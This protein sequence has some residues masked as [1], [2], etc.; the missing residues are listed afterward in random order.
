MIVVVLKF[1]H[2]F[3][4][5]TACPPDI[6]TVDAANVRVTL[7]HTTLPSVQ[8]LM[9]SFFFPCSGKMMVLA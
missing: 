8:V 6:H 3:V 2:V 9:A 5:F 7:M 4:I 1:V